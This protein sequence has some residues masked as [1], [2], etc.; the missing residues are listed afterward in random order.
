MRYPTTQESDAVPQNN[1]AATQLGNNVISIRSRLYNL[2]TTEHDF[3]RFGNAEWIPNPRPEGYDSIESIHDTIHGLS[4]MGGHM[5]VVIYASFDPIFMLHHTMVD[6]AFAMWQVLN[7]SSKS[8]PSHFIWNPLTWRTLGYVVPHHAMMNTFTTSTGEIQN[9]TTPLTPFRNNKGSFWNS[10]NVRH[11]ETLG[12]AYAETLNTISNLPIRVTTAINSLYGNL[13]SNH[14][15]DLGEKRE[16]YEWLANIRLKHDYVGSFFIHFFLG[17]YNS[18]PLTWPF[19][20]NRVASHCV[21]VK[22]VHDISNK[23]GFV[24]ATIPLTSS[25]VDQISR[26]LLR[27]LEPEEVLEFIHNTLD[28]RLSTIQNQEILE[29]QVPS[30]TIS[31]AGAKVTLPKALTDSPIW[32]EMQ[33]YGNISRKYPLRL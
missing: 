16:H 6:R 28:F 26:G 7:P 9:D 23:G 14:Q 20:T 24:S 12:Y 11:T 25:L 8:R 15:R 22:P 4:G 18:D 29:N 13:N 30:L 33:D 10:Q 17:P 27:S 2:L 32:D 3:T 19:E 21:F 1:L 31:L 5:N